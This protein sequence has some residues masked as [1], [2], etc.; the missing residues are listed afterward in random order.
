MLDDCSLW[1]NKW[2]YKEEEVEV[3]CYKVN[4]ITHEA[5]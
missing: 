2:Q 1:I 4:H 3:L 5:I